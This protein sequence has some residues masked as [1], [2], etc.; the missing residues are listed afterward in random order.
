MKYLDKIYYASL[1]AL[2][3]F[4]L[5]VIIEPDYFSF[6]FLLI[7][8]TLLISFFFIINNKYKKKY[9]TKK[10]YN[11][12]GYIYFLGACVFLICTLIK[13]FNR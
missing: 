6:N 5:F 4:C 12:F 11:F 3:I 9:P 2:L 1:F 7:S 10:N 13:Y 8:F